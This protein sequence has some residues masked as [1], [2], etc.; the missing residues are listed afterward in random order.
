MEFFRIL[1]V[2]FPFLGAG[3]AIIDDISKTHP[4]IINEGNAV[5][6]IQQK[7]NEVKEYFDSLDLKEVV[8]H[9]LAETIVH[10][11]VT[12]LQMIQTVLHDKEKNFSQTDGKVFGECLA[13]SSQYLADLINGSTYAWQRFFLILVA[14]GTLYDII[15]RPGECS[16]NIDSSVPMGKMEHKDGKGHVNKALEND[17]D[18]N[19]SQ[20]NGKAKHHLPEQLYM[21]PQEE[22]DL[23]KEQ[24]KLEN[25]TKEK[26]KNN[27]LKTMY[28]TLYFTYRYNSTALGTYSVD[29]FFVLSGLLV[30]YLTLKELQARNGKINWFLYYFHRF[31]RL[32]PAYMVTIA[33]WT[34]LTI[35]IG[36]GAGK[37]E[38]LRYELQTCQDYW[39]T[40][41]LYIN[42]LPPFPGSQGGGCA[43]WSWYLANDMQ[44][45][46]IS[47][48]FIVLLFKT[49]K[50]MFVALLNMTS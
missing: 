23:E 35:H 5:I 4:E 18:M 25:A 49:S 21:T 31:W 47:P 41:L 8:H 32:T 24:S 43:G 13:D 9:E 37:E 50:K 33:I 3:V 20:K 15:T 46:I 42:T 38:R 1:N 45:F 39:W 48:L 12:E 10:G 44:F 6:K 36:V 7:A 2:F 34:S 30:T 17:E 11:D 27:N 14:I 16:E 22:R 40:N 26:T 28:E 19:I 29:S